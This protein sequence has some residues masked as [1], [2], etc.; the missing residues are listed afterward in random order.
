MRMYHTAMLMNAGCE[1]F[2]G[3]PWISHHAQLFY[4]ELLE[5]DQKAL[6]HNLEDYLRIRTFSD[7]S[8]ALCHRPPMVVQCVSVRRLL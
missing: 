1:T 4:A 7:P 6:S 3:T 8:F 2:A 5:L